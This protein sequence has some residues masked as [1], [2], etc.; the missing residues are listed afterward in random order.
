VD[1]AEL[2]TRVEAALEDLDALPDPAARRAATA[3]VRAVLDLYGEGLARVVE[4]VDRTSE[5]A[6]DELVAH[7]MMVHG[8]HPEPVEARVGRA[9]DEVRPYLQSHGGDVALLEVRDGVARVHLV[10]SCHGCPSSA[11]TLKLAVEDAVARL[12]PDVD[13][14]DAGEDA[15]PAPPAPALLQIQPLQVAGSGRRAE[16]R[17]RGI[18]GRCPITFCGTSWPSPVCPP[19]PSSAHRARST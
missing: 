12:A 5:M 14:V 11:V 8:L 17:V 10:G 2:I 7:L 16:Q 13:R 4:L 1:G 18:P 15:A 3:A 6:G 9:L 19:P